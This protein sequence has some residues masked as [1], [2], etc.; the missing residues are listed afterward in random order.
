[1]FAGITELHLDQTLMPWDEVFVFLLKIANLKYLLTS[2]IDIFII[3]SISRPAIP[4]VV[5]KQF[6]FYN[7]S[8][9]DHFEECGP[10]E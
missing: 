6:D 2:R 5:V 7:D 8:P 3:S 9:T 4:I 10:R 1:M